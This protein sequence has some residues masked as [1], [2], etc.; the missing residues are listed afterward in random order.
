[1]FY[2]CR[3]SLQ[4]CSA[5]QFNKQC[6]EELLYQVQIG[7]KV[8]LCPYKVYHYQ[9]PIA[10]VKN[11][12]DNSDFIKLISARFERH[13]NDDFLEDVW[14]GKLCSDWSRDSFTGHELLSE[15]Q[16][17]AFMLNV[18]WVKPC[19]RGQYKIGAIYLTI[20]NLPRAE[21]L[22]KKWTLL[23]GLIPGPSE[24]E[25][26]MNTFLKPLVD[27]LLTLWHGI[28]IEGE[29]GRKLNV[30]G[31]LLCVSCDLPALRKVTQFL[32]HKANLGCNIC[33]F[34]AE[35]EGGRGFGRMSYHTKD[36]NF[37]YRN[38]E[39][40]CEQGEEYKSAH[41][42]TESKQ[43]AKKNGVR[44]SELHRL[45]YFDPSR[46][47]AVDPMH[48]LMLGLI[49]KE[50]GIHFSEDQNNENSNFAIQGEQ[51]KT[52]KRRLKSIQM[53]S[54][55]GRLPMSI[56]DKA[57]VDGIT[58]Q[59]WLLYA[60]VFARPCLLGLL[61]PAT[62][63][64][65]KLLCEVT[66]IL[67]KHILSDDDMVN[68]ECKIQDHHKLFCKVY[69]KWNVSINNHMMLHIVRTITDFGPAHVFWCFGFERLNGILVGV[70]SS[71][72]NIEKELIERFESCQVLA[73]L[74]QNSLLPVSLRLK[75]HEECPQLIQE[76]SSS[77]TGDEIA[78]IMHNNEIHRAQVEN[79]IKTGAAVGD[80]FEFQCSIEML[81]SEMAPYSWTMLGPKRLGKCMNTPI[82]D[83]ISSHLQMLFEERFI[84]VSR[85]FDIYA[86]CEVN[87]LTLNS[88]MN[89]TDRSSKA[90]AYFPFSD[91]SGIGRYVCKIQFFFCVS[92]IVV[93]RRGDRESRIIP[94][95]FVDWYRPASNSAVTGLKK[96]KKTFYKN[97]NIVGVQRLC[98]RVVTLE[99]ENDQLVMPLPN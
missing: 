67:T 88:C 3:S 52:L 72:R 45:P 58:A 39:T 73:L 50:A 13:Q 11:L 70:P 41:T 62:Y 49:K 32:G 54:D 42:I 53:P 30:R 31:I 25:T 63:N 55:C 98:Q 99:M 69:G 36:F 17:L 64:C 65:M 83:L 74:K 28:S 19:K 40:V 51:R 22:L 5:R 16:N 27:D 94:F 1:M 96:T 82:Y 92:A 86:R 77:L 9:S 95:A 23:V 80:Y 20:L 71:G 33:E 8:K 43:I 21:R 14:D 10:W 38:R 76:G 59:Q 79:Y 15:V 97:N 84:A 93:S 4:K 61:P 78:K 48:A 91:E 2:T 56:L 60:T 66:D 34:S 85:Q 6:G 24:P 18:D 44:F 57:S 47:C 29:G 87:G 68:L 26:H 12:M 81:E 37:N 7:N 90:V 46:M 35:R 75:F 89:R